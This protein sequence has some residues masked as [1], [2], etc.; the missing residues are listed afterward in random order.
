MV[1]APAVAGRFYPAQPERLTADLDR[2]LQPPARR[3]RAL[4]C[5]AP[6]AGYMY[7]GHVAGALYAAL[8]LPRRFVI[9]CPN[10]YGC[11]SP[12]AMYAGGEWQTPLGRVS[13]DQELA[14]RIRREFPGLDDDP[15]AH[16]R[17]HALE[18]QLP[19]LQRLVPGFTFVP[20]SI[21]VDDLATLQSL[22]KALAKVLAPL[23]GEALMIASSDMN[24]YEADSL[25]RRK[26]QH[27]IDAMLALD[28]AAL[29]TVVRRE[30]ISM[31]GRGP[32]VAA[33]TAARALGAN[34]AELLRY[35]TSGDV[36]GER[37]QVVG[38]AALA[39]YEAPGAGQ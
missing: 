31:C 5:V 34:R 24:H 30:R 38:Y 9:L 10:H 14:S 12:L 22:G 32:A 2:Y 18:V 6:H 21:G 36:S 20:I 33:I 25:T 15:E 1:R 39:F 37:D 3:I 17:E 11:G 16:A 27:A 8:E 13:V 35:A 4:G 29:H 28:A 26:D 7:S 23:G 19:F